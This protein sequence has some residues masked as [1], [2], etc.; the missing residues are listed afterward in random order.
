MRCSRV[1]QQHRW[2]KVTHDRLGE[3]VVHRT[4]YQPTQV[5]AVEVGRLPECRLLHT[6]SAEAVRRRAARGP[7]FR[8]L[9]LVQRIV[10]ER[11][12]K[13]GA[14]SGH[15]QA[16]RLEELVPR[17]HVA[18]QHAL[19]HQHEAHGLADDHV[20]LSTVSHVSGRPLFLM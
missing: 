20:N 18:L 5:H 12:H 8:L 4:L 16:T 7:Y 6:A 11:S 15:H 19:V 3:V 1:G 13:N 10:A 14:D 2:R 9:L 17:G